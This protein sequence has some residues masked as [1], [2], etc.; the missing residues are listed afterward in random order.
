VTISVSALTAPTVEAVCAGGGSWITLV[1][2]VTAVGHWHV[3]AS[4]AP[5]GWSGPVFPRLA[6]RDGCP[7]CG[8]W[9]RAVSSPESSETAVH[10]SAPVAGTATSQ[11]P[12]IRRQLPPAAGSGALLAV[13]ATPSTAPPGRPDLDRIRRWA[14]ACLSAEQARER[15]ARRYLGDLLGEAGDL[16]AIE[17]AAAALLAATGPGASWSDQETAARDLRDLLAARGHDL[18]QGAA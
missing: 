10:V 12:V 4:G 14:V 16:R 13:L 8:G 18:G 17:I 6:F 5:C 9:V 3:G 11:P 7:C 1:G 15:I 2:K